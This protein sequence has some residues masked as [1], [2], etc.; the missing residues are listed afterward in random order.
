MSRPEHEPLSQRIVF[1]DYLRGAGL[2]WLLLVL[3]LVQVFSSRAA[4]AFVAFAVLICLVAHIATPGIS[5]GFDAR[6]SSHRVISIIR[7]CLIIAWLWAVLSLAWGAEVSLGIKAVLNMALG[8]CAA[9]FLGRQF[10]RIPDFRIAVVL[11]LGMIMGAA[12][13]LFGLENAGWVAGLADNSHRAFDYNRNAIALVFLACPAAL[14]LGRHRI[15]DVFILLALAG[16]LFSVFRSDS[17]TAKLAILVGLA[18]FIAS[19]FIKQVQQLSGLFVAGVFLCM[20]FVVPVIS[21]MTT[22]L[23]PEFIKSGHA[24]H[25]LGIWR[26]YA[27]AIL[28][29]PIFGWGMRSDRYVGALPEYQ[30][31]AQ[32]SGFEGDFLSPHNAALELWVNLGLVGIAPVV[33][34]LLLLGFMKTGSRLHRASLT[35]LFVTAASTSLTGSS[36]FQGWLIAGFVV[37][38][39]LFLA[40]GAQKGQHHSS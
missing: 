28:E 5:Y 1:A 9:W 16:I 22:L 18:A 36:I 6:K 3:P 25:R 7:P 23:H 37:A 35:A 30:R 20:P 2:V 8:L 32:D 15:L 34:V 24:A 21:K 10:S 11:V 27:D 33:L 12:A 31:Y 39:S 4:P 19:Y 26:G 14:F 13:L 29:N 40:I 38:A 17:E